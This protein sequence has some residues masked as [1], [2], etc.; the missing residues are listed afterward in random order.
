MC[1]QNFGSGKHEEGQLPGALQAVER[2]AQPL[3]EC[4][5][6]VRL[7]LCPGNEEHPLA[8]TLECFVLRMIFQQPVG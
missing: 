6:M 1:F 8:A 3:K 5:F 4:Q 7:Q 2:S